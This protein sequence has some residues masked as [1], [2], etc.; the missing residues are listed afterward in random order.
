MTII[1]EARGEPVRGGDDDPGDLL[2]SGIGIARHQSEA[3]AWKAG[4]TPDP[5]GFEP[6]APW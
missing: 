6:S 5:N 2:V 3:A 4:C 1:R